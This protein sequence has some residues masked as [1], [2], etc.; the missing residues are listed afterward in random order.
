MENYCLQYFGDITPLANLKTIHIALL[1]ITEQAED[2]RFLQD[3]TTW[4]KGLFLRGSSCA[5][6]TGGRVETWPI[7]LSKVP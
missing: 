4:R 5:P 1:T 2:S 3:A 7:N 6:L